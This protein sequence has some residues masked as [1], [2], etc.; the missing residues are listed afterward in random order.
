MNHHSVKNHAVNLF[1][2][3]D[4]C[5]LAACMVWMFNQF[6]LTY[7]EYFAAMAGC[8]CIAIALIAGF[9]FRYYLHV[10]CDA[11]FDEVDK[12]SKLRRS[13][14]MDETEVPLAPAA[15]KPS[16]SW[17]SNISDFIFGPTSYGRETE[18]LLR[19]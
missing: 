18:N 10:R 13:S 6:T 4:A 5:M 9:G 8:F 1:Y 12:K 15:A 19:K 2:L 3:G 11:W 16:W 7:N 14:S 17:K